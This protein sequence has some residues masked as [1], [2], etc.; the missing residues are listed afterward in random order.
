Q[1]A[2]LKY[3]FKGNYHAP[4]NK[5]ELGSVLDVG[6]GAGLWM[7]DMA[8]EFP[9][10]EIHGVD[11]VVPTRKRLAPAMLDS[12]PSNC[13]FHKADATRGLPFPDNTFDYCRVRLVLWGYN[14]NSFPDL[15]TELVRVTKKGGWIEFV[16]MD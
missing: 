7:R 10:T 14:L 16:D 8:L 11:A 13:F 3:F 9:L 15:L 4:L 6:C 12:M 1:H 2:L 5:D